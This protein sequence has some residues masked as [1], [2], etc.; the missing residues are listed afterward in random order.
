MG[1]AKDSVRSKL[2]L[3]TSEEL[4]DV[5]ENLS[6]ERS[7]RG[8]V[9][10]HLVDH[11]PQNTHHS[12]GNVIPLSLVNE[13][14]DLLFVHAS[15]GGLGVSGIGLHVALRI[16]LTC[17]RG[18]ELDGAVLGAKVGS[19]SS[20]T[21]HLVSELLNFSELLGLVL[22]KVLEESEGQEQKHIDDMVFH[23]LSS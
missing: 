5:S 6:S 15:G 10:V 20:N 22:L 16:G 23:N 18:S 11:G 4:D 12:I 1:L 14:L 2:I 9:A 17:S 7:H 3:F 21:V 8:R 19:L 13:G